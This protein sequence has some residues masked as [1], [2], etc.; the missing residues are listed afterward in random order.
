LLSIKQ[1]VALAHWGPS[2]AVEWI[3]IIK[4]KNMVLLMKPKADLQ[5]WYLHDKGLSTQRIND[6]MLDLDQITEE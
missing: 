6:M 1:Q 4:K 2:L 3:Q 5:L